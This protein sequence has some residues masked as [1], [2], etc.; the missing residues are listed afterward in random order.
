[1]FVF[2]PH[3]RL[4]C[5]CQA[6][7]EQLDDAIYLSLLCAWY[8]INTIL[9][10]YNCCSGLEI[11]GLHYTWYSNGCTL[12]LTSDFVLEIHISTLFSSSFG[13]VT[14]RSLRLHSALLITGPV[15]VFTPPASPPPVDTPYNIFTGA[16]ILNWCFAQ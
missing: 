13:I 9:Y 16:I 12:L 15:F 5:S 3:T 2:I 14:V 4:C 1:M 7:R 6:K 8:D 10:S 11:P